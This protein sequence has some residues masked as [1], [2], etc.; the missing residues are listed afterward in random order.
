MAG[1]AA[2]ARRVPGRADGLRLRASGHAGAPPSRRTRPATTKRPQRPSQPE[3]PAP[4]DSRRPG[5]HR[6]PL[7]PS[8]GAGTKPGGCPGAG[9]ASPGTGRDRDRQR[10]SRR[11]DVPS[12]GKRFCHFSSCYH[13][14]RCTELQHTQG[15]QGYVE[16][17]LTA[18]QGAEDINDVMLTQ[19]ALR[20][21][22]EKNI[23][24]TPDQWYFLKMLY[25]KRVARVLQGL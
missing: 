9:P 23:E 15:I 13:A 3:R 19:P 17:P 5:T 1:A 10:R 6:Q 12:P 22:Q 20:I 16:K 2:A 14:S 21:L 4:R 25:C 7:V 8:H 24:I 18:V 11:L